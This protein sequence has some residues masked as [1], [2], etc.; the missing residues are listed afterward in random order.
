VLCVPI[1]EE[2][3]SEN[4]PQKGWA[5]GNTA[6]KQKL[7]GKGYY[8][9]LR[10]NDFGPPEWWTE[11]CYPNVSMDYI[12]TMQFLSLKVAH[13]INIPKFWQTPSRQTDN[14]HKGVTHLSIY[15]FVC[16]FIYV[17]IYF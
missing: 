2:T 11:F 16:L 10:K 5:I 3:Q 13:F 1:A 14:H 8:K 9:W 15:L 4:C 17:F 7:N 6:V 12:L